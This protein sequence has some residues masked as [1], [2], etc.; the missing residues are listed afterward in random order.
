MK[1]PEQVPN[2]ELEINP[3]KEISPELVRAI[4]QEALHV[5]DK[6]NI[7]LTKAG[8][9]PA[10]EITLTIRTW[11]EE[12]NNKHMAEDDIQRDVWI[13][14]EL[15]IPVQFGSRE[16]VEIVEDN[17]KYHRE[18]IRILIRKTQKD[19]DF[20]IEAQKSKDNELLGRAY[21]F[22]STAVDA[23]VGKGKKLDVRRLPKKIRESE[24]MLFSS[25]TLSADNWRKEIEQGQRDADYIKGISPFIYK[26]L[27]EMMKRS[28]K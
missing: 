22:P 15:G 28:R 12:E 2:Q 24:A 11:N 14:K 25:P 5:D 4:E 7:L 20:L 8:L 26:E 19:L 16:V 3:K 10:S 18:E 17:K 21:G 1:N 13:I 27:I 23:W 9:K 6:V